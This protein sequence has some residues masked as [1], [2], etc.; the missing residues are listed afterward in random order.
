MSLKDTVKKAWDWYQGPGKT[1][2]NEIPGVSALLR[3]GIRT[4][5]GALAA[6]L[7]GL[8]TREALKDDPN[9]WVILAEALALVGVGVYAHARTNMK[10]A[11]VAAE[12]ETQNA[13]PPDPVGGFLGGKN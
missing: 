12:V 6:G 13:V 3:D 9:P 1:F 10:G 7:V 8:V 11:V 2:L 5:E 4:S